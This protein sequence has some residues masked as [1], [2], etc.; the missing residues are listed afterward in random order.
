MHSPFALQAWRMHNHERTCRMG[1]GDE[2]NRGHVVLYNGRRAVVTVHGWLASFRAA[3]VQECR[4]W[5]ICVACRR[6]GGGDVHF[7]HLWA[8]TVLKATN[9]ASSTT[10]SETHTDG[11]AVEGGVESC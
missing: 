4:R 10:T 5:V 2:I 7:H 6:A 8:R 11:R 1:V 9:T 3:K